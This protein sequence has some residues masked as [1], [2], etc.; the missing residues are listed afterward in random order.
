MTTEKLMVEEVTVDGA[1]FTLEHI[2]I[3]LDKV[4]LD[5]NN[6]RIQYRLALEKGGKTLE[7]VILGMPEVTKLR[8]DIELNKGLREKII[9]QKQAN[10]KYKVLEGNCRT[11]CYRSLRS[12]PKFKGSDLW[13]TISAR[14]VP[15]DVEERKVA[16]LLADQHVAGKISWKAHEKAGMIF[17]MSRELNMNQGDI[18]TYLRQS[19]TTVGRFLD[20]YTFMKDKFLTIDN[21]KFAADGENKWSFFD[22]FFRSKELRAELKKTPEFGDDFCRWVGEGR[23]SEGMQ[24]RDLPSIL[25]NPEAR[26]KFE[27]VSKDIAFAE[28][29]K[30][31]EAADPEQGSDFFKLL[32]KVREACTSA[33]QVKEILRI[34]TDKV[35][36]EHLLETYEA[37]VDFMRLADVE[38]AEEGRRDAA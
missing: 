27:K 24:M 21:G 16:I 9:V 32:G 38:P 19:K 34:R 2:D 18:A 17:R 37:L 28:A 29:M 3:P 31:V 10:G 36:R 20:A 8:K 11:V 33:A 4:E 12:M 1:P 5:E 7:E 35:A 15:K 6:P 14:A 26:K 25:K 30:L 13:N 23:L 22:E